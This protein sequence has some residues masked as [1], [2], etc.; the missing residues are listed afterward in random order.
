MF[1]NSRC[2]CTR[3]KRKGEKKIKH[4]RELHVLFLQKRKLDYN[5]IDVK[6]EAEE[7]EP[8][9]LSEET[10]DEAKKSRSEE[11]DD[12]KV[13]CLLFHRRLFSCRCQKCQ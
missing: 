9:D 1:T 13:I 2:K 3:R 8:S 11:D 4:I 12:E 5:N 10:V 7:N 6:E